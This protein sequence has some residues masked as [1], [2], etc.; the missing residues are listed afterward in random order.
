MELELWPWRWLTSRISLLNSDLLKSRLKPIQY[1]Q[2]PMELSNLSTRMVSSSSLCACMYVHT[3]VCRC[4]QPCEFVLRLEDDSGCPALQCSALFPWGTWSSAG[5]Q[6]APAVSCPH[7]HS[8][9]VAGACDHTQ[10]FTWV[11][12]IQTQE[13]VV[14][15]TRLSPQAWLL[16][17][18]AF[19]SSV[20]KKFIGV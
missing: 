6:Q 3:Q 12:R 13:Q 9:G 10:S 5:D 18:L 11:M 14:L 8:T 1:G 19:L 17:C 2:F 20:V 4:V 15:P 7:P 16:S